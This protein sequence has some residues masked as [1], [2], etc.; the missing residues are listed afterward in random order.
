MDNINCHKI[1]NFI[2]RFLIYI[3]IDT[4]Y[5]SI[6][7]LCSRWTGG[8]Q[9]P[10]GLLAGPHAHPYRDL[11]PMHAHW[12]AQT[13]PHAPPTGPPIYRSASRVPPSSFLDQ[14]SWSRHPAV[15]AAT[16]PPWWVM[17]CRATRRAGSPSGSSVANCAAALHTPNN[18]ARIW[19]GRPPP[20]MGDVPPPI[21]HTD[22]E[23]WSLEDSPPRDEWSDE[24]S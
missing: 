5:I 19:L 8:E 3:Y 22:A 17:R 14:I 6:L 10:P 16:E 23:I 18:R 13:R 9:T 15:A 4:H 7:S 24:S 1:V 2:L 11:G 20:P 21:H 12:P